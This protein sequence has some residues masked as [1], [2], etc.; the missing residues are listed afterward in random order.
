MKT[1]LFS[2]ALATG[3]IASPL[4]LLEKRDQAK[5]LSNGDAKKFMDRF[6]NVLQH[7][8]SDRGDYVATA[9]SI[10]TN[11]FHEI[12]DSINMLAGKPLGSVTADKATY[13]T[14][15][16]HAPPTTGIESLA[17]TV[18]NCNNIIWEWNMAG[19]G[20]ATYPV[21]GIGMFKMVRGGKLGL[22]VQAKELKLEFNNIAWG[23]DTGY[24]WV[25][26]DGTLLGRAPNP[27]PATTTPEETT[28]EETTG[29]E[30]TSDDAT[31][32]EDTTTANPAS[33]SGSTTT[34]DDTTTTPADTTTG[35][36]TSNDDTETGTASTANLDQSTETT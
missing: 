10:L 19:V 6:I 11:D 9:Q 32:T 35:S 36:E 18:S 16:Q 8:D 33:D 3:A 31:T 20:R 13:I 22:N 23:L 12:S 2:L 14:G 4:G 15:A 5:C 26:Q 28:T 27:T 7:I 34:T 24:G 1:T 29:D 21:K 17:I 25:K 30:S